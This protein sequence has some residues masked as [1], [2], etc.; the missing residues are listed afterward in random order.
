MKSKLHLGH[1]MALACLATLLVISG[2]AS[3]Q[4]NTQRQA[5]R[6]MS[7]SKDALAKNNATAFMNSVQEILQDPSQ[8]DAI[9][10]AF[11]GS[12]AAKRLTQ[13]EVNSKLEVL[14]SAASARKLKSLVGRFAQVGLLDLQFA[15]LIKEKVN[16]SALSK[17]RTGVIR[18]TFADNPGD[19]QLMPT[20]EDEMIVFRNTVSRLS[21]PSDP[22][23]TE[24]LVGLMEYSLRYSGD[25]QK[26][27]QVQD[28]LPK[29]NA[30][31]SE[32]R[33]LS[34]MFPEYTKAR[35]KELTIVVQLV[36]KGLD[37]LAKDD[38]EAALTAQ[39]PGLAIARAGDSAAIA[40][41]IER[42]R[43]D[44]RRAPE[45]Q[46]TIT[47]AQH[48]VDVVQAV[49]LMPRNASYIYDVVSGGAEIDYGYSL[50][51]T[52]INAERSEKVV[53]GKV[54]GEYVRC[55]NSRIQNVFGGA[56][57]AGFVANSD[58]RSRCSGASEV[59]MEALRNEVAAK[60]IEAVRSNPQIN[61]VSQKNG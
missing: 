13:A 19:L 4:H 48:E 15:A 23:R 7:E 17:N 42:I 11:G 30:R 47:Y 52:P 12:E 1:S 61:A 44:E 14:D 37:R 51:F 32:L 3:S 9:K 31:R 45:R 2:C 50:E 57:S 34:Q 6:R 18:F 10:S 28:V 26:L 39:I 22:Q 54:G 20:P 60:I 53:R 27:R 24:L 36:V 55:L 46:Q 25:A 56:S 58:M 16:Q 29:L 33:I 5:E 35:E 49:L 38:L 21:E 41:T 43:H 8:D 59:S 40:V